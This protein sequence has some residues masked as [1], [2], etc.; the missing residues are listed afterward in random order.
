MTEQPTPDNSI[1]ASTYD[2]EG[3]ESS[4]KAKRSWLRRPSWSVIGGALVGGGIT[5]GYLVNSYFF[6]LSQTNCSLAAEW[7]VTFA[8]I[9]TSVGALL[10][11][12]V[13]KFFRGMYRM[14][15]VD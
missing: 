15:R 8:I 5:F 9:G 3:T 6:C 7:I 4:S 1:G 10:G 12:L 2:P 11:W 13:G 14:M